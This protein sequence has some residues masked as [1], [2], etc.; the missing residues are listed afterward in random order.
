MP[1]LPNPQPSNQS[2]N[3]SSATR[4]T[5]LPG[6]LLL[7]G[8]GDDGSCW[9]P[10]LRALD[11]PDLQ[12]AT[13]DAPAHGGRMAEPG[14]TIA[15]SDLLADA[16][17]QARRLVVETGGPIVVGGHSM[18]AAVALGVAATHPELAVALFLEDP[19]FTASIA[20]DD[21][22]PAD[23][24][25]DLT[26]LEAWILLLQTATLE[27]LIDSA[28]EEHPDWDPAEYEPWARSKYAVDADAFSEPVHW[29]RNGWGASARRVTCPVVVAAGLPE[30]GSVLAPEAEADLVAMPGWT[31]N[32]L[33]A[34][35]D[36]RRD[37]PAQAA[38][39]LR[40]LIN[41]VRV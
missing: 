5:R 28:R 41:S 26:D 16:V 21:Q 13:P 37:S 22:E 39:L 29:V 4:P 32:R 6:L 35:H 24:P 25:T 8:V 10:F 17:A 38:A 12:V 40:E 23:S 3:Q 14:Q 7:H 20:E 30:R 15:W 27:E 19:P 1:T 9:G 2:S 11:L 34:G 33:P 31:V 18:G 36:V